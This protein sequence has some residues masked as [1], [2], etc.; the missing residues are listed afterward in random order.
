MSLRN[1]LKSENRKENG[2]PGRIR[3][4]DPQLRRLLLYPAE[5]RAHRKRRKI[6]KQL[7]KIFL[8]KAHFVTL[9]QFTKLRCLPLV[10][11]LQKKSLQRGFISAVFHKN[12]QHKIIIRHQEKHAKHYK[13]PGFPRLNRWLR[14]NNRPNHNPSSRAK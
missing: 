14:A 4:C 10:K 5:L 9:Y 1:V 3:T 8:L 12:N 11:L 2:V 7:L 6:Y 13:T